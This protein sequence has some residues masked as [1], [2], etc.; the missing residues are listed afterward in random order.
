TKTVDPNATAPNLPGPT[1]SSTGAGNYF[2][3]YTGA[4]GVDW[5]IS[6]TM[7]NEFRGGFLYNGNFFAYNGN[8]PTPQTQQI[9]WNFQNL[10]FFYS[11]TAMNGTDFQIPTG[12][13]YPVFNLSDTLSWQRGAH[14]FNFGVSWWREQ[15]HYYNGVL[16]FPRVY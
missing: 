4:V 11:N 5:T 15:N 12:S 14:S 1:F 7:V 16:G 10:P 8:T 13:Y 3:S 2:K 6:P 9:G